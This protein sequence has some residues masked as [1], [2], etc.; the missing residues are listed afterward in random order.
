VKSENGAVALNIKRGR[1]PLAALAGD[2]PAGGPG[3]ALED[4]GERER[5]G[6]TV[7]ALADECGETVEQGDRQRAPFDNG[8]VGSG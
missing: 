3:A 2:G 7:E 4:P 5:I 6:I 8:F 1:P